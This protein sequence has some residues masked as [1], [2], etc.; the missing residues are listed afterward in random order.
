[1]SR[2]EQANAR[3]RERYAADPSYAEAKRRAAITFY[4]ANADAINADR[5]VDRI[6]NN[7]THRARDRARRAAKPDAY[8]AAN[9]RYMAKHPERVRANNRRRRLRDYGLTVES[10]DALIVKQRGCC[11]VCAGALPTGRLRHVDHD[12]QTGAV[13]GVL[14]QHCNQL[15]GFAREDIRILAG[16]IAYLGRHKP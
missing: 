16:A 4:R 1:M 10:F 9:A 11:A 2:R 12:H 15:L 6:A 13:R 14:C 7:E 8:K 3:S 5:Q